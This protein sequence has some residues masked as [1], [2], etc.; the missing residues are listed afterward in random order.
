MTFGAL[1]L[2]KLWSASTVAFL[3][4]VFTQ[5]T[6][7]AEWLPFQAELR[8]SSRAY[9]Q[10]LYGYDNWASTTD[11]ELST[12]LN[13]NLLNAKLVPWIRLQVPSSVAGDQRASQVF[14]EAKEAWVETNHDNWDFRLGNQILVWGSGDFFNPT[15][16]W[17]PTDFTDPIEPARLPLSLA[18]LSIHPLAFEHVILD[19]VATPQF[20]PHR[21]PFSYGEDPIAR[22]NFAPT[23]SRWLVPTPT[24][25]QITQN[26]VVPLTYHVTGAQPPNEWQGGARLR[27][28]RIGGCDFNLS[29][30]QT[31]LPMPAFETKVTGVI[32]DP[33]LPIDITIMPIF[34]RV[35]T[36]GL[37]A[38]GAI[39]PIGVRLELAQRNARNSVSS[40]VPLQTN[41]GSLG[42]DYTFPMGKS[43]IY[44]NA[45]FLMKDSP[46][47]TAVQTV[48]SI[49][50]FEPFDR[51]L[52]FV[53]EDRVTSKFHLGIRGIGS[54]VNEDSWVSPSASYTFGDHT[55]V[56]VGIDLFAGSEKGAYGQYRENNRVRSLITLQ[57]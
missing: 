3:T 11:A 18:K 15:D 46:G 41:L 49:P 40:V 37:D 24:L 27:L 31:T 16:V 8:Q 42:F 28:I 33:N 50:N 48:F 56:E 54:L 19:L 34:Y 53:I 23:D 30:S 13:D 52:L 43:E 14:L 17:N 44:L 36:T 21:L 1:R 10:K 45:V 39:G 12:G 35:A 2:S 20:R 25:A 32:N 38:A 55:I 6:G 5:S 22:R 29:Y 47:S 51:N 26:N 4:L 9:M 57:Y 7:A